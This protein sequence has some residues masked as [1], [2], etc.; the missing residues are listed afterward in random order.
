MTSWPSQAHPFA[1]GRGNRESSRIILLKMPTQD[2]VECW[3]MEVCQKVVGPPNIYIYIYCR[4]KEQFGGYQKSE[5]EGSFTQDK[6]S[7]PREKVMRKRNQSYLT[8]LETPSKIM[9]Q[10]DISKH[11]I[12]DQIFIIFLSFLKHTRS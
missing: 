5:W 2:T 9:R 3:V 7:G 6:N 4:K 8:V 1:G 10:N 11:G 12:L